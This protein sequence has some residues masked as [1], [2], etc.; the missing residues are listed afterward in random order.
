MISLLKD[1]G[2]RWWERG[3]VPYGER[4][5]MI[6]SGNYTLRIYDKD[7]V[8][9]Y[10]DTHVINNSRVYVIEGTN[11]TEIISGQSVIQGQLLELSSELDYALMPDIEI[12]GFNP[13]MISS[14]LDK[15]GSILGDTI[16]ICPALV[17]IA[18]TRVETTGN[19]INSTARMPGNDTVENGTITILLDT[20]YISGS[21][22]WVN[23]TYTDNGTL[24]FNKT[25]YMPKINL[26]G[27]NITINASGDITILR[28]TQYH[29]AQKFY[30]LYSASTGKHTTGIS[31][32]NPMD[33]PIYDVCVYIEFSNRSTPD[34]NTV[35]IEDV[36]NDNEILESGDYDVTL[37]WIRFYLLSI[38]S[39]STRGFTVSYYKRFDDAYRYGEET[40]NIPGFIETVWNGLSYN[41]FDISWINDG[42]T[43]F[44]GGLYARIGF[45]VPMKIDGNSVRIFDNDNNCE[46]DESDYIFGSDFIRI[47]ADG[48]GDI[49]PGSGRSFSVY[50]LLSEYPGVDPAEIHL[51]TPLFTLGGFAIT[52]FL[53]ILLI[54]LVLIGY[55]VYDYVYK[56]KKRKGAIYIGVFVIFIFYI[57]AFMG[58]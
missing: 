6:P 38:D 56:S 7:W 27:Q 24:M 39:D 10:N 19:W 40:I 13:P 46:L 3:I 53:F 49:N 51:N 37:R 43:I 4:E 34:P 45:D 17:V 16:L 32:I 48:L 23:I 42:D 20:L 58:V 52:P 1:G 44:R 11:L 29:Q 33:I 28:E 18:T 15:Q 2:S 12:I 22:T 14:R 47:D 5:F 26:Y 54:G 25:S 50:F 36:A 57:L 9:L 21:A 8:E 31:V 35:I 30:W 55:G 41:T